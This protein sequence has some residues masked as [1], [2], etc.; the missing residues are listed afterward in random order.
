MALIA[1]KK[2]KEKELDE[3]KNACEASQKLLE[4]NKALMKASASLLQEA[5]DI[6]IESEINRKQSFEEEK[7]EAEEKKETIVRRINANEDAKKAIQERLSE[8]NDIENQYTWIKSLSDTANGTLAGK[9]KIMLETYIQMTY[10]DRIIQR[11]NTRFM[12]MSG[13]QYELKR[14]ESAENIRSQSGL[15][16]DVIDHYNGT[17]RSVKNAFRRR[18][19]QG[20]PFACAR[21]L[22]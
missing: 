16:L 22:R 1:Q 14:A 15:D 18:V 7:K 5:Q 6:H 2:Q 11:A 13:G 17:S 12:I 19:F 21:T 4:E 9:E 8:L 20:F 3:A 10:F